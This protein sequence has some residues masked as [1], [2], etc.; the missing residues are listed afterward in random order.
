MYPIL[1]CEGAQRG[2]VLRDAHVQ[3]PVL[4]VWGQWFETVGWGPGMRPDG[5]VAS[6]DWASA[7]N[8]GV[9]VDGDPGFS[10]RSL[11]ASKDSE[12]R[13][14]ALV[15]TSRPLALKLHP[16]SCTGPQPDGAG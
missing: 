12:T 9:T 7:D 11:S 5:L 8:P 1:S 4:A 10:Q 2:V 3:L 13:A 16:H 6:R 14:E 15:Q